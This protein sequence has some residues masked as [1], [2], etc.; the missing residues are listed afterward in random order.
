M[1]VDVDVEVEL[2]VGPV[3]ALAKRMAQSR[4][5]WLNAAG[6]LI[7][8]VATSASCGSEGSGAESRDC[9]ERRAVLMVRTG[10][11][12]AERVSRQIAP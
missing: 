6:L 7:I 1:D 11:H 12:F 2:P 10:V 8:M 5:F 4:A 3:G 9:R